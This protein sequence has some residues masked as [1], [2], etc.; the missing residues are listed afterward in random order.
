M[1]PASS[2]TSIPPPA[3]A[4]GEHFSKL[5]IE[6]EVLRKLCVS[7]WWG[8][9][10]LLIATLEPTKEWGVERERQVPQFKREYTQLLANPSSSPYAVK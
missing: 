9:I 2:T 1:N 6:V 7:L 4:L 5:E 8:F 3:G 10:R